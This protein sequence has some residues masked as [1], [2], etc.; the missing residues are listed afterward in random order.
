VEGDGDDIDRPKAILT[1]KIS[2]MNL[3]SK[4]IEGHAEILPVRAERPHLF[5]CSWHLAPG[6]NADKR[7][8]RDPVSI[9]FD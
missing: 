2:T 1:S 7:S 6:T 5:F 9:A 8:L 4:K 3:I